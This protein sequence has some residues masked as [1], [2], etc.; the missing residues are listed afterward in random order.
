MLLYTWWWGALQGG[1]NTDTTL[2]PFITHLSTQME[3]LCFS[4]LTWMFLTVN[5]KRFTVSGQL[6]SIN[7]TIILYLIL[8]RCCFLNKRLCLKEKNARLLF[9]ILL[10]W[11]EFNNV[12]Q[13]VFEKAFNHVTTNHVKIRYFEFLKLPFCSVNRRENTRRKENNAVKRL[14]WWIKGS[15]AYSPCWVHF[16]WTYSTLTLA[17]AIE[18]PSHTVY[19]HASL[20][21]QRHTNGPSDHNLHPCRPS[22]AAVLAHNNVHLYSPL[23]MRLY[24]VCISDFI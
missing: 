13:T 16:S 7:I 15:D 14:T 20:L 4:L 5:L 10:P 21:P 11:N 19:Y 6:D 9:G 23:I 3:E 8:L 18:L 17:T 1:Y 12:T 24:H 22:V 2:P